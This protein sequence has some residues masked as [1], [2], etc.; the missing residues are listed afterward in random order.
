[1]EYGVAYLDK[2]GKGFSRTEPWIM[3]STV[4][5]CINDSMSLLSEGCPKAIPFEYDTYK[6]ENITWNY[7]TCDK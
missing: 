1:M 6:T 4:K 7:E 5:R 3:D 2:N